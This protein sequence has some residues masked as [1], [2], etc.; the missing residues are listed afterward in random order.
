[1]LAAA[2]SRQFPPGQSGKGRLAQGPAG[3]PAVGVVPGQQQGTQPVGLRGGGCGDLLAGNQQDTQRLPV[4]VG[5]QRRKPAGVQAQRGQHRQVGIDRVGLA[6]PAPL[7]AA[8]LLALDH[9]QA[10]GGQRP[11]QTLWGSITGSGLGGLPRW[12]HR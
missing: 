2:R 7:L 8:G 11:R 3:G 6:L 4:A 12:D 10:R 9:Q 1:M 5:A